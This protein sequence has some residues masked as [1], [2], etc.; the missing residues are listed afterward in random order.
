MNLFDLFATISLDTSEYDQ[1]V[2]DVSQGGASLTSKLKSSF[3]TAGKAAAK[4]LGIIAGA[5]TAVTGGLVALEQSTEEYRIAQGKLNTAFEA[6]GYGADTAKQAYTEFYKILGDTDTATEASQL[7]AKL[8]GNEKD[9]ATWTNI[10]AGVSG[11]FGDSLPIEGLIEASNETAKVGQVTGVLADALNWAGIS[12]DTFNA[13]LASCTT[14]SERNQLIMKTLSKT[15]DKASEAFYRNNEAIVKSREQQAKLQDTM[16]KVGGAVAEV[17]NTLLEKFA[18]AIEEVGS[19]FADFISNIDAER[20][21]EH[22]TSFVDTL[23]QNGPAILSVISGIAAG[24]AAWKVTSIVG[25][26]VS[27]LSKLIPAIVGAATAQQGLNTAMK[28]NPIGLIISLIAA[29]GTALITLWTTNEDFRAAVT[30]IWENIK[31]IFSLAWESIKAVWDAV[32]PYFAAI[33]SG[34]QT[35]FSAVVSFFSGIFSGAWSAIQGVWNGVVGFFA[36]VW[37]GVQDVFAVV[38]AVLS[39]DFK[40]AW[41]AIKEIWSGVKEFFSG[42]WEDIKGIFANAWEEF[43][44]IGRNIVNGIKDGIWEVWEGLTS[45]FSG[46]WDSLFGNRNVNVKVNASAGGVDGSHA[47]G[48]AY[49]PF[50]GYVA[51]LHKGE[52]VL[53]RTQAAALRQ[54]TVSFARSGLGAATAGMVN[55]LSNSGAAVGEQVTVNLVLPDGTKLASYLLPS[56]IN[57]SKANGTPILRP[58]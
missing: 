3:S 41:E 23:V 29:L 42:V 17:K 50:D 37:D 2:K 32:S 27:A 18:P 49:V 12:E 43:K 58:V 6:A 1:G 48:L 26:A 24:F 47:G 22:I 19:R 4:G 57:V 28:M 13:Q 40:G 9:V 21:A 54:G 51:E 34:I 5:A 35:V 44:N 30:E 53:N 16:G 39:G 38:E 15:Y 25:G 56:L 11:T 7:L 45:W 8:A 33:W 36:N 20:L 10:A 31:G 46:L 55:G 14:E 52:M